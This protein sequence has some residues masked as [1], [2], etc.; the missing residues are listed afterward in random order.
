MK[1]EKFYSFYQTEEII[2]K[3]CTSLINSV[4]IYYKMHNTYLWIQE[5]GNISAPD[6][7]VSNIADKIDL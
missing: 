2:N 7:L 4:R 3:I 6:R 1:L 5:N